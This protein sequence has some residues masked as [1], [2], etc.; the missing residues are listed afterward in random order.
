MRLFS[1]PRAIQRIRGSYKE[2]PSSVTNKIRL[3]AH[4]TPS[5]NKAHGEIS[6][7]IISTARPEWGIIGLSHFQFSRDFGTLLIGPS[8]LRF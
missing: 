5:V 3:G 4:D 1:N 7:I 2:Y 6:D 8:F